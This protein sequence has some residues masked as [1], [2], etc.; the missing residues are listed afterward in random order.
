MAKILT[1]AEIFK[2]LSDIGTG[3][4][5]MDDSDQYI[6]LLHDLG[7]V[8]AKHFGG[9]VGIAEFTDF[10]DTYTVAFHHTENVPEN[11]GIYKDYDTD[12]TWG[13]YGEKET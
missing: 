10:M 2:I 3:K 8:I 7:E 11:G 13:T 5:S 6:E 1:Y 4:I 12:V 9:N